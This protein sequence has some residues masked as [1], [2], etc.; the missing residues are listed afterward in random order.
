MV[1]IS[2]QGNP[3]YPLMSLRVNI[4]KK[5]TTLTSSA[6]VAC[7]SSYPGLSWRGIP[8][9]VPRAGSG[10]RGCPRPP[11]GSGTPAAAWPPTGPWPPWRCSDAPSADSHHLPEAIQFN[12]LTHT[13]R[14]ANYT[15]IDS[16]AAV[17]ISASGAVSSVS[18]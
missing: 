12:R 4:K 18:Q 15:N 14:S 5:H 1:K 2:T 3:R 11:C 13:V 16:T 10:V 7:F 17:T 8:W 9:Q 6:H